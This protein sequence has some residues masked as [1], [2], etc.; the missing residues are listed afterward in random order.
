MNV[1]EF[2]SEVIRIHDTGTATE[3]S[4]RAA[5]GALFDGIETN[6]QSIN[7][8]KA[9]TVGRPDFVF[10]HGQLTLGHCE[11]KDIGLSISP[12][13]MNPANKAQF[14]RYTKALPNLIYTNCL[15]FAFYR[16]GELISEISIADYLL[17]IQPQ[18]D[19][20][21]AL[22]HRLADF[23]AQRLQ[24]ITSS[25]RLAKLMAGK[26]ALIKDVLANALTEDANLQTELAGQFHAFKDQL[27]HDLTPGAFADIYAETIANGMFAAR[28]HDTTLNSFSREEAKTGR[29]ISRRFVGQSRRE[30][31]GAVAK[32]PW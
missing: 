6:I 17:G 29:S 2:L 18:P 10:L 24:T 14:E 20:F 11:A 31:S 30:V 16:E 3:H 28:L 25:K 19:Q 21:A 22:T 8:P 12:K 7:E 4:Y 27:I 15:D 23:T 1:E 9:V 13:K 32:P 26:A 5:L